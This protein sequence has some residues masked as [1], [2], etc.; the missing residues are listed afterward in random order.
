M[1]LTYDTFQVVILF[2]FK[3]TKLGSIRVE[4]KKS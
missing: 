3:W 4:K 2:L 1:S